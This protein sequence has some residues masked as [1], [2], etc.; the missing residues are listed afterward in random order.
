MATR[1]TSAGHK[2][3]PCDGRRPRF[4]FHS[5]TRR[6][7]PIAINDADDVGDMRPGKDVATAPEGSV[8]KSWSIRKFTANRYSIRVAAPIIVTSIARK[9]AIW[10]TG[11]R[12]SPGSNNHKDVLERAKSSAIFA[13]MA[14]R[15]AETNFNTSVGN[16]R[17]KV[18]I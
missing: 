17:P 11:G 18:I 13:F 1:A 15:P 3:S 12:A 4:V 10:R 9:R 2:L 8:N 7:T 14:A 6:A 16:T 5:K